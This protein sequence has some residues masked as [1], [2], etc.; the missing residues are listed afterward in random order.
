MYVSLCVSVSSVSVSGVPPCDRLGLSGASLAV[1]VAPLYI[2]DILSPRRKNCTHPPRR[3]PR[4]R[5]RARAARGE[6][7]Y[8]T[9]PPTAGFPNGCVQFPE[10]SRNKQIPHNARNTAAWHLSTY[11]P[12]A[13][14]WRRRARTRR[15]RQQSRRPNLLNL[16]LRVPKELMI[17][18]LVDRAQ[19]R[20]TCLQIEHVHQSV[21]HFVECADIWH[22]T[23]STF[24][25]GADAHKP[26][27]HVK[28][29][30]DALGQVMQPSNWLGVDGN[31][32]RGL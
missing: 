25:P 14:R 21:S 2:C 23:P 31:L 12:H 26:L 4:R 3:R 10:H 22:P 19:R 5:A 16:N 20:G 13:G 27:S 7:K 29:M 30:G 11:P 28:Y 1:C 18:E 9:P 6:L 15:R 24:Q 32:Q 8:T 17:V